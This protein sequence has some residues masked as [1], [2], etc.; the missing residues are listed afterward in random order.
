MLKVKFSP[1]RKVGFGLTDGEMLERVW[2]YQRKFGKMTKEMRP[3]HR[4]D[5]LSD[6]L[7]HYGLKTK[8]KLGTDILYI[9]FDFKLW[10]IDF[11]VP[12]CSSI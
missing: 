9:H 7:L 11:A 1:R 4:V 10:I 2:A 5:V 8:Q 12:T 6:V 3:S